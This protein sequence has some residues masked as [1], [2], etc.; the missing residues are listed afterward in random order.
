M[1][2]AEIRFCQMQIL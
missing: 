2:A 1:E